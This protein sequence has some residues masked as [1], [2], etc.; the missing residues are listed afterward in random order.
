V[1]KCL[2]KDPAKRWQTAAD[3]RDELAW[4]ES[5]S[6]ARA[7]GAMA[8]GATVVAAPR[9]RIGRAT[10]TLAALAAVSGLAFALGQRTK[11]QNTAQ[12]TFRVL[13]F[14]RG[15]I[16]TARFAPDGQTIVYSAAWDGRPLVMFAT[17]RDGSESRSLGLPSGAIASISST[18]DIAFI[19]DCSEAPQCEDGMLARAPLAGGP[20]R[21]L[22]EHVTYADWAPNGQDLAVI[23]NVEGKSRLESPIGRI[24]YEAST[25]ARLEH[26]RFSRS[27]DSIAFSEVSGDGSRSVSIVN[28]DGHRREVLGHIQFLFRGPE[29][30]PQDNELW[31]TRSSRGNASALYATDLDGKEHLVERTPQSMMLCDLGRDGQ[32]LI[33]MA[34]EPRWSRVMGRGPGD[35]E[36][37]DLS[38]LS[39]PHIADLST[40]GR[41]VLLDDNAYSVRG[42][43]RS[44]YLRGTDGSPAIRLAEG[45][46]EAVALS[47]DGKLAISADGSPL[48]LTLLPT[49]P[50]E[51]Q[52]IATPFEAWHWG[53]WTPDG[54]HFI[55]SAR[56][57]RHGWRGY[58]QS[59]KGGP[60]RPI[61]PEGIEPLLISPD[62][63][64]VLAAGLDRSRSLALYPIDGGTP[65]PV[66]GLDSGDTPVQWCVDP[67]FLFVRAPGLFPA[68]VF[69][70]DL[71]TGRKTPW[72]ELAPKD[73]AGIFDV[74]RMDNKRSLFITP[75]GRAYAYHYLHVLSDLYLVEGLK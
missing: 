13:T 27:G 24:L 20:E 31:F 63:R 34:S 35:S 42:G 61:T 23:H 37:R 29:W 5:E 28:R 62:G 51:S 11:G 65:R 33:N 67:R 3:L 45:Y 48:R 75:D 50:G 55:M 17:R 2:A 70:F 40:D 47:R 68:R 19:K 56:E 66:Q 64:S 21:E 44:V 6:T 36:E 22:L 26:I 46:G 60:P 7:T 39:N 32:L 41:T 52:T 54:Q 38:V 74:G 73:L 53:F 16:Q 59:V 8:S 9:R 69:T 71:Q 4:I 1:K 12:P 25:G 57:P 15:W 43:G 14:G 30:S 72:K 18:G 58:L 49:G 10:A